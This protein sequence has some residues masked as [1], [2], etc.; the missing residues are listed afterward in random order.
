[1]NCY[2]YI[3]GL[4]VSVS[5]AILGSYL[6]EIDPLVC[7]HSS[8]DIEVPLVNLSGSRIQVCQSV[9]EVSMVGM[10]L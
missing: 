2:C 1:M 3:E 7:I 10:I 8:L 5:L 4:E 6:E 9:E